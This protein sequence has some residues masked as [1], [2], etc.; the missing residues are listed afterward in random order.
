MAPTFSPTRAWWKSAVVYQIYPISFFDSNG[1][2]IGDLPGIHQKLDYIK[3]LGTDVIWLCP[4]YKSPLADMGYDI[5]DYQSIDPR[6]GTL[7]DWDKLL[8]GVHQRGMKLLMD[9]VANHTSDEHEWFKESRSSKTHPKRDW[10][11]WRPPRYDENGQR[12]PPNNWKSIFQGPA[13]E[14]D[15]TTEEYFLHLFVKEQPDLNWENSA[16]RD[17]IW[18]TMRFWLARGCDGFRMDVINM[19]SKVDGLPDAVV[20]D[21]GSELQPAGL[22]YVN[23]PKV[24]EYIREMNDKVLSQHDIMTV[25]E[26]PLTH[27][28]DDIAAYVLPANKELNMVFQFQVMD[29]DSGGVE[30]GAEAVS[31]LVYR[32]WKLLELKNI[33]ERWQLYKREQGY[34]NA[35]FLENHD[36]SRSVSRY[37]N[38]TPQWRAA[39]AKL[40]ALYHTT[41]AGTLY[42]YQGQELGMANFSKSWGLEEYKDVATINFWKQELEKRQKT[43]GKTNVDM[44]DVLAGFQRKARDHARTPVQWNSNPHAGFTTGN[45]WM[46]VNDD[47]LGGWNADAENDDPTSVLN[48]WRRALAV[49]R[50]HEVLIYGDFEL[51][52]REHPK[53]FAYKRML[54]GV[55]ALVAMNFS[56]SEVVLEADSLGLSELKSSKVAL[57]NY[58]DFSHDEKELRLRGYEGVMYIQL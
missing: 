34:W 4:I 1:D 53:V 37:G 10:Y 54:D 30:G 52:L 7:E 51:L 17:A 27:N 18:D 22:L 5:S 47:Y 55:T 15:E 21:P 40:L 20:T 39:S 28:P 16:V 38:D 50:N 49:R 25:G 26:T 19:I 41:Q 58:P 9:L 6:Y 36:H 42:V 13:W 46:R 33:T 8:A 32:K 57:A 45:P 14:Y 44:S 43:Q 2:G 3:A 48:F 12:H 24:H 31:P 29:I 11:I 35:L 23:G 56:E